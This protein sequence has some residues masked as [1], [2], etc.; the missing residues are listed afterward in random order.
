MYPFLALIYQL[1]DLKDY[2]S[3]QQCWR[4]QHL[5]SSSP[6]FAGGEDHTPKKLIILE[7]IKTVNMTKGGAMYSP[8]L[9]WYVPVIKK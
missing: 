5:S 1:S 6:L 9:I 2:S 4:S 7:K 8:T 3:N